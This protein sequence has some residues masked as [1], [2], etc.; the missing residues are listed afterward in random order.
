MALGK[1]VSQI[2][3]NFVIYYCI[4]NIIKAITA[5]NK[6]MFLTNGFHPPLMLFGSGGRP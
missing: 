3:E 4:N 2:T 1:K 6:I 5:N